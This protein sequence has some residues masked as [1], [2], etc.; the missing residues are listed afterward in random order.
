[1]RILK[2]SWIALLLL[3]LSLCAL[4]IIAPSLI[5]VPFSNLYLRSQGLELSEVAGLNLTLGS[6]SLES[7]VL[8]A[9]D[10]R[11]E[12][13]S[14]TTEYSLFELV[15]GKTRTLNISSLSIE[16][17]NNQTSAD[18]PAAINTEQLKSQI[19]NLPFGSLNV[20]SFHVYSEDLEADGRVSINNDT[21]ELESTA[22]ATAFN[23]WQFSTSLSAKDLQNFSGNV[24]VSRLNDPEQFLL[25]SEISGTLLDEH[26]SLEAQSQ[27]NVAELS[28]VID[29]LDFVTGVASASR[30]LQLS[31]H[32]E[33]S[34]LDRRPHLEILRNII[35][36]D[37]NEI[38]IAMQQNSDSPSETG[39]ASSVSITLPLSMELEGEETGN[40]QINVS[41][42]AYLVDIESPIALAFNSNLQQIQLNC[43]TFTS[44]TVK[45]N[46]AASIDALE[47]DLLSLEQASISGD[48]SASI[49]KS[50]IR[51]APSAFDVDISRITYPPIE[52]SASL[53][54]NNVV[55]SFTDDLLARAYLESEA[56]TFASEQ[57][58]LVNPSLFGDIEF[59]KNE[60]RTT[61]ILAMNSQV[62]T[63]L[64]L[65]Q[66]L[67]TNEGSLGI[68]LRQFQFSN[69][70]PLSSLISQ[71]YIPGDLVQGQVEGSASLQWLLDDQGERLFS[72]PVTLKLD[73]LSGFV[74]ETFFVDFT[75]KIDAQFTNPFG[76]ESSGVQS[77][78][79]ATVDTGLPVEQ[80]SW[81]FDFD[82][83]NGQ[84]NLANLD[85]TILGGK[86]GVSEF[87]YD[88][89]AETNELAIVLT[90]LDLESLVALADYPGVDVDGLISGYLPISITGN[91]ITVEE[92]LVGALNPGGTIRY[93]PANP[94]PSS[95]P[96]VQ[97]VNDALS[98]YQYETMNTEVYY[99]ENGD[100]RMEVQLQ[101]I[102]P[103]M[104]GGQP[105]NLNVNITDNIPT[106]L[107]SL[108]ASRAI[109][110]A[111]EESL[112]EQ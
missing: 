10:Y 62:D 42:I 70:V 66:N 48:F 92:G 95:N 83:A 51:L 40:Y 25:N 28:T 44:C 79:I 110:D 96:S 98:N 111:L 58:S 27:I 19:R 21:I 60:F 12:I 39:I 14:L 61:L 86:I 101:G 106:L 3:F 6:G 75:T 26:L 73:D 67:E 47:I 18:A 33:L 22:Q 49:N 15:S 68:E 63:G 55:A 31:T 88:G 69:L 78:T 43:E 35:D 7:A 72:G 103:D 4:L 36:T 80:I 50:R 41:D 93:I 20:S 91:T 102:N 99:D 8:T 32:L 5:V 109:T 77:A 54:L 11:V 82:S 37:S 53:K 46:L 17:L 65:R 87:N 76:V 81:N 71:S 56:L 16:L 2:I 104:N 85:T 30:D 112:T 107:R 45:G 13:S 90:S 57:L 1:M 34:G 108:R 100:L 94:I 9:P 84:Y 23:N 59:E 29:Q 97:L 74:D 52:S 89:T 105:I 24:K 64:L 38:S